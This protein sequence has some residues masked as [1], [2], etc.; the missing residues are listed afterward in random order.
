MAEE[1][2]IE[3]AKESLR[4]WKNRKATTDYE[5]E[6]RDW[7]IQNALEVLNGDGGDSSPSLLQ[8]EDDAPSPSAEDVNIIWGS[9]R[10]QMDQDM[11][12]PP[13]K[14]N[15]EAAM[16][17]SQGIGTRDIFSKLQ[18]D[19]KKQK[20]PRAASRRWI[21]EGKALAKRLGLP[22]LPAP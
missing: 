16:L 7:S 4:H 20:D 10:K 5:R 13:Q 22:P 11:L 17:R 8:E 18:P 2:D 3:D 9:Y 1:L 14:R 15:L 19:D 21:R 6:I 12:S